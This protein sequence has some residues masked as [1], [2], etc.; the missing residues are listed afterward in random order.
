MGMRSVSNRIR[1]D[2]RRRRH[3][4]TR[5]QRPAIAP[6]PALRQDGR[7]RPARRAMH[8]IAFIHD[9][10]IIMPMGGVVTVVLHLLP[11]PVGIASNAA[12]MLISPHMPTYS[13]LTER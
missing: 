5:S 6:A 7:H 1:P 4:W 3:V 9:L 11:Q 10:A 2:H 12:G 13:P 8:M